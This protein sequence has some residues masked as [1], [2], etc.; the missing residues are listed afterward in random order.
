MEE[1]KIIN[2]YEK[3]EVSNNGKVRVKKSKYV[4]KQYMSKW[5]L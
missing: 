1:W 5:L 2:N 3:Y 4:L